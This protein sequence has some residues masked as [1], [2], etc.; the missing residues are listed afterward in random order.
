MLTICDAQQKAI[1]HDMIKNV[2]I[3]FSLSFKFWAEQFTLL[4]RAH[5]LQGKL[6]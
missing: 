3:S 4:A 1:L 5:T 6:H 2:K